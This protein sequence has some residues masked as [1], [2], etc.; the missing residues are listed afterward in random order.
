MRSYDVEYRTT[1]V[2]GETMATQSL[3]VDLADRL[4]SRL[5]ERFEVEPHR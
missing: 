5:E 1:R 4:Y 2:R 3:T